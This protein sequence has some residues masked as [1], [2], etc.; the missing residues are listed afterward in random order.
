MNVKTLISRSPIFFI[1]IIFLIA[2]T[3]VTGGDVVML[4]TPEEARMSVTRAVVEEI[5][6][7]PT[8]RINSPEN[9]SV[10]NGPFRLY[11]EIVKKS[12]GAE[13]NMKSLKVNY[14]KVVTINITSRVQSYVK[15]T[16]LDVPEA[17]FPAGKH[18]TE[19]YIEDVD[20][21]ASRKLFTVT[22]NEPSE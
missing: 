3:A 12:G 5:D 2:P 11:V 15:G 20:G 8:I 21:N 14:L 10:L 18:R 13:V 4:V 19:I 16:K 6:N 9:G 1:L 17:E 7:G 22:V